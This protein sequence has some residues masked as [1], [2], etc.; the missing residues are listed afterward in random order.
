MSIRIFYDNISYRLRNSKKAIELIK[1]VITKESRIPGD[2]CFIITND[3]NLLKINK[4]FLKRD[5]LT[6]VIAFD[7]S[8]SNIVEGEIYISK[9]AVK[10]NSHN[11]KVSLKEEM[12]RV[13]IHGTLHLCG[14]NDKT[15]E[16]REAMRKKENYWIEKKE[17]S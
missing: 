6:D 13:M 8:K 3:V 7:Y 12:K 14:Y 1:K 5:T 4:E 9:E 11:Y 17:K 2:L 10:R 15:K 16:E